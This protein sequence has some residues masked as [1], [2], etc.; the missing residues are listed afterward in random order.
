[1]YQGYW[2][3]DPIWTGST[4]G[5]N[6]PEQESGRYRGIVTYD[7]DGFRRRM[8]A[9]Y[10]AG[11]WQN[12]TCSQVSIRRVCRQA[13]VG[14]VSAVYMQWYLTY[15]DVF[16]A[17]AAP[18][19]YYGHRNNYDSPDAV[20]VQDGMAA[21]RTIDYLRLPR[22]YGNVLINGS[23]TGVSANG[24]ML[25]RPDHDNTGAG[26]AGYGRWCAHGQRDPNSSNPN[27]F[28]DWSLIIDASWNF[29]ASSYKPPAA[30]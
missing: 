14:V 19:I 8:D 1:L 24:I 26:A 7:L 25:Y 20:S 10:G 5:I 6:R 3:K 12:M 28:S 29:S 2:Q 11:V 4:V 27:N 13:G 30:W 17:A 15:T 9:T 21:G 18:P 16:D 23:G 22:G